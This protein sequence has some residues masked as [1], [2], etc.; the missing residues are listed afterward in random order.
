MR[1]NLVVPFKDKDTVKSLGAIWDIARKTW[2]VENREDLHIFW[3]W[4]P[5]NQ[6]TATNRGW[7]DYLQ[8]K[9]KQKL[10]IHKKLNKNKKA[11]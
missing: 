11:K 5:E 10:T 4:F 1:V 7:S 2:Y 3:D 8:S 9:T 6:K